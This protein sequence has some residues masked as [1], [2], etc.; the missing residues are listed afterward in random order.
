MRGDRGGRE[1]RRARAEWTHRRP[2]ARSRCRWSAPAR[3]AAAPHQPG[4]YPDARLA[5]GQRL[6]GRVDYDANPWVVDPPGGI[7]ANT[8]NKITDAALS[9]PPELRLGRQPPHPAR[10]PADEGARGYHTRESFIEIQTRHGVRGGALLLPLIGATSGTRASRPPRAAAERRRQPALELLADWN[11]EM[12]EHMPEPLIYAAWVR[13]L[14]RPADPRRTR[15]PR[16]RSF[17][18][19]IRS[20]SSGCTATST[21]PSVW[22]DVIQSDAAETCADMA[23]LA[24]DDALL[25]IT[26]RYR[27]ASGDR[28]A[29]ATST[30]RRTTTTCWDRSPV[31]GLIVNIRQSTSGGDDTLNRGQLKG[32][33]P[34]PFLNIHGAGYRG[35]LRLRGPRQLGVHHR[36]GADRASAVA[37]LRRSAACSGGGG[38]TS[39]CRSTPSLRGRRRWA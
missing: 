13:A 33:G 15:A 8:N 5:R 3:R 28:C 32:T 18:R 19:W 17:P 12:N 24:L 34:D 6:A 16:R 26:E 31:C 37:A 30:R 11:G 29:G 22:C 7:V 25:W 23:R 10:R 21:A 20:S 4:A 27:T 38:S 36:D 39:R 2:R 9:R 14:Q 1:L 35:G